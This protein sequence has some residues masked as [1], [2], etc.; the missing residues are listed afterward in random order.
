MEQNVANH[1][2][3][4]W[5]EWLHRPDNKAEEILGSLGIIDAQDRPI[6]GKPAQKMI[7]QAVL[8]AIILSERMQGISSDQLARQWRLN[9]LCRY[10]RGLA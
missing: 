10:R 4:L 2:S 7:R 6:H 9:H 1:K 8:R 3:M 5:R